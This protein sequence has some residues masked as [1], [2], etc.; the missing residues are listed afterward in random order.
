MNVANLLLAR[1]SSRQREIALRSALGASRPRIIRQLLTESVLLSF[2]AAV[3]G[4]LI[5]YW[6][7]SLL[8]SL[9]GAPLRVLDQISVDGTAL[10]FAIAIAA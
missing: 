9:P 5:A 4:I 8:R 6:G 10:G 1:A 3:P 2:L 7:V